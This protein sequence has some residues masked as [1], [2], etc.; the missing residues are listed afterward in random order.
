MATKVVIHNP[1][2]GIADNGG[3]APGKMA[4][5]GWGGL[6]YEIKP[7]ETQILEEHLAAHARKHNPH[8][9]ILDES[10]GSLSFADSQCRMAE[11]RLAE[12]SGQLEAK[13]REFKKAQADVVS[14][15][16]RYKAEQTARDAEIKALTQKD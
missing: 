1:A 14:A 5:F 9:Q 13:T 16:A 15:R 4:Q 8:L 3:E 6:Q 10:M 11:A 2:T 7:G 12:I